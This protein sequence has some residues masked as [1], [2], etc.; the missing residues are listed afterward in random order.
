MVIDGQS[1]QNWS[2][3]PPCHV[4]KQRMQNLLTRTQRFSLPVNFLRHICSFR[5]INGRNTIRIRVRS[6]PPCIWRNCLMDRILLSPL[7]TCT[8]ARTLVRTLVR[9]LIR[10]HAHT[11]A[12]TPKHTRT[13][14]ANFLPP[15]SHSSH[16]TS[17][18][19]VCLCWV[20]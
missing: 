12:H 2:C 14:T 6:Q 8:H 16:A 7:P 1:Q 5:Y 13:H 15:P 3:G 9:T 11:H 18:R 20:E 17:L 4:S 19:N 10:T